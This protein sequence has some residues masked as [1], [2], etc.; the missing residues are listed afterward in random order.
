MLF[1]HEDIMKLFPSKSDHIASLRWKSPRILVLHHSSNAWAKES[2]VHNPKL[3]TVAPWYLLKLEVTVQSFLLPFPF[4]TH[5]IVDQNPPLW[6]KYISSGHRLKVL[7]VSREVGITS[8]REMSEL[9]PKGWSSVG[10]EQREIH[11]WKTKLI[12][13]CHIKSPKRLRSYSPDL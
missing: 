3:Q 4:S 9:L 11:P 13:F 6:Y 1:L 2:K 12:H 10:L 5:V 8:F 7:V